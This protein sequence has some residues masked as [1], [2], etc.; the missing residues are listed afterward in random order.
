MKPQLG[1]PRPTCWKRSKA[2]SGE[3]V[4]CRLDRGH[5]SSHAAMYE[6][7]EG[8]RMHWWL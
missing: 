5:S 8:M 7:P 3:M 4:K 1:E 2:P 6:T